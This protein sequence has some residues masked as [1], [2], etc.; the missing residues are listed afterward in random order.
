MIYVLG[1]IKRICSMRT[2]EVIV[3]GFPEEKSDG[4]IGIRRLGGKLVEEGYETRV[5]RVCLSYK[6][7][8]TANRINEYLSRRLS[9]FRTLKTSRSIVTAGNARL[10]FGM[11]RRDATVTVVTR[12]IS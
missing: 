9:L 11:T 8:N 5:K 2:V 1:D 4:A 3:A 7:Q 6:W 10:D 12:R